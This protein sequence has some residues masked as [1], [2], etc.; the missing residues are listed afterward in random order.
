MRDFAKRAGPAQDPC[1]ADARPHADGPHREP[2]QGLADVGHRVLVYRDL[3]ALDR[4]PDVRAPS[5]Q[6]TIHL[7]GNMERYM[8]AF[9]G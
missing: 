9:D 7:T 1:R 2:P 8:W 6:L 3:V 4:N 5:R